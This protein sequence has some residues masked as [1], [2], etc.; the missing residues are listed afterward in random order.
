[1][2]IQENMANVMRAL[3]E[4]RHKSLAE[5]S[6]ELEI[7]RSALQEYLT[8]TGNPR[9]TTVEHLAEKL[10]IDPVFL[11]SDSFNISQLEVLLLLF[12]TIQIVSDLPAPKRRRFAELLL[13]ILSLWGE[14]DE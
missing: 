12:D 3:K 10:G 4:T 6:E 9:I 14:Q 7:S 8:G 5:L 13:E 11:V 2:G 1:M